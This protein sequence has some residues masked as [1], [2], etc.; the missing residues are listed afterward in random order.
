M[1]NINTEKF[2][3]AAKAN[4]EIAV[5]VANTLLAATERLAAHNLNTARA[6]IADSTAIGTSLYGIKDAQALLAVPASL[7]QPSIE[8][9]IAYSRGIYTIVTETQ[10]ALSRVF[11]SQYATLNREVLSSIEA[12]AKHAPAGSEVAVTAVRQ[13]LDAANSA[14]DNI[15]K[16]T[17]QA[18]EVAESNVEAATSATL[19]AV[20]A[21]AAKAKKAA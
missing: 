5:T 14:Y 21:G 18:V 19:K 12:A 17:K 8:K 1:T 2:A 11:E 7:A 4:S 16:A 13:A 6:L 3:A 20:S 9:A 10:A 15:T